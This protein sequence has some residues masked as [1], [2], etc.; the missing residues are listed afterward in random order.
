MLIFVESPRITP[1]SERPWGGRS[2]RDQT[3]TLR[4]IKLCDRLVAGLN[5]YWVGYRHG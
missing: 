4:R 3:L 2:K 1:Y 5:A